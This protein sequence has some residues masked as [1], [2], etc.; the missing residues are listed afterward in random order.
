VSHAVWFPRGNAC[1][2]FGSTSGAR[3]DAAGD[4][5]VAV[6]RRDCVTR[7]D[8]CGETGRAQSVHRHARDVL[9]ETGKQHCHARN[10][11]IV[12]PGLVRTTEVDVLDLAGVHACTSNRFGDHA[13]RE[14]VRPDVRECAAVPPDRRPHTSEDH[15]TA[16]VMKSTRGASS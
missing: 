10:V 8:D 11:A 1:S 2:G 15:G 4:E 13:R 7:G 16:H 6:S 14:V 9:R 3:L 5:K 12:L